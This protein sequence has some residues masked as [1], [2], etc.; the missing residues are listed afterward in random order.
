M[1]ASPAS[2]APGAVPGRPAAPLLLRWHDD[3]LELRLHR[4][5]RRNAIDRT[6]AE[7]LLDALASEARGARAVVL[8]GGDEHF[9]SGGDVASMP[10]PA[11]GLFGPAGRLE[12]SHRVVREL[13]GGPAPTVAAVEGYAIGVAWGLA[14]ACD[15]V[16]AADD[17]FFLAPFARRGLAADGA[18]AWHLTRALG[19]QGAARHL[20]LGER[21]AAEDAR[22]A[23]LVTSVVAPGA[24]TAAA[25]QVAATL[26]AG[27]VESTAVTRWMCD[28]AEQQGLESFLRDERIGVSLAGHGRDAAAGHAAFA[29]RREAVFR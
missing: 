9:S 19:R 10:G 2:P 21:L 22:A 25:L 20:L 1:P 24:A 26:A 17:A 16:V 4:P 3:V 7:A 27:P 14:L 13:R 6:L 5:A 11:D 28:T 12:L 8:T 23:G 29:E 18:V 15:V